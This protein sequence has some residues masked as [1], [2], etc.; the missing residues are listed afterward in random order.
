MIPVGASVGSALGF[1]TA[2]IAFQA[3]RSWYQFIKTLD[4][5]HANKL[6]DEMTQQAAKIVRT[7]AG[8]APLTTTCVAYMR[9]A[10][11]GHEIP[12]TLPARKL[13]AKDTAELKR[14]FDAAYRKLYGRTVP[15]MDVEIMSWSVQASE[16]AHGARAVAAVSPSDAPKP[17]RER[18]LIG[19][20]VQEIGLKPE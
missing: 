5:A 20:V 10:G 2:P 15:N 4:T 16:G 1:L 8:N 12:V 18:A 11:Q 3:V 14:R 6:V 19:K 7:A 13:A 9:Y 17:I